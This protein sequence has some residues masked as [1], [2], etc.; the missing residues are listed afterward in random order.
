VW[1]KVAYLKRAPKAQAGE[2]AQSGIVYFHPP[3]KTGDIKNG[4]NKRKQG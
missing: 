3:V 4:K 1:F 2:A